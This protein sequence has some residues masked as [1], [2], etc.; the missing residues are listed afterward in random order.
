MDPVELVNQKKDQGKQSQIDI[1]NNLNLA[2]LEE[3][4]QCK[5]AN[6]KREEATAKKPQIKNKLRV[7][8]PSRKS[9]EMSQ[10][11]DKCNLSYGLMSN[12]H[13]KKYKVPPP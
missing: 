12:T 1:T 6:Y 13:A 8:I 2:D 10:E 3:M 11:V 9:I 5:T 7:S 4:K